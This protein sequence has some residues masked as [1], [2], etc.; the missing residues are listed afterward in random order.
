M[1]MGV[2]QITHHIEN[3]VKAHRRALES[4]THHNSHLQAA[5]RSDGET[6]FRVGMAAAKRGIHPSES[7]RAKMSAIKRGR[8]LSAEWV[9]AIQRGRSG[10]R[11]NA[12]T[13]AKNQRSTEEQRARISATLKDRVFTTEHRERL[14]LAMRGNRNG[15]RNTKQSSGGN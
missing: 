6:A 11:A 15:A 9:A 13:R 14:S 12:E 7:T 2:Y 1:T 8:S 10:Y 3:Q 4:G 5:W